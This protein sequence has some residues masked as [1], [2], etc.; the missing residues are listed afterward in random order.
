MALKN[1]F[2]KGF[3]KKLADLFRP[4]YHYL[5][6]LA[7]ALWYR[8]PAK[9]IFVVA[10]TGTKGKTTT[11]EIIGAILKEDGYKVAL[12][13]TLHFE[14]A[15]AEERN[16]FKMTMPGRFFIQKFLRR[17][18]N[19]KCDYAVIEMT[20]EGAQQFRHKFT[21]L[22]A[23]VFTNLA[24]EHIESHGSFENYL[25][26]KLK[27]ARAL[28]KSH[29]DRKFIIANV[30]DPQG[31]TFLNAN[32]PGKFPFS[33][34]N[35]S[36]YLIKKEGLEFALENRKV[37][38]PL[39]GEFNLYNILASIMFARSQN[40]TDEIII[41]AVEKFSGLRGR[42]EKVTLS[43][44]D[45]DSIKQNFSVIVD[46]AH[47]PDSLEKVYQVF[48]NTRLICVLG[49]TGGGRDTWKRPIMG[50]I[51]DRYCD[52]IILTNEDPY[53]EDPRKILQEIHTAIKETA[54]EE[55]LDRRS[56]IRRALGLAKTG[57]TV[58]ITGKGTDPYIMGPHGQKTPWDDAT[59]AREEL[60]NTLNARTA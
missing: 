27:L 15:G 1:Y 50:Q 21:A 57:D 11:V 16:L 44:N 47:T 2:Q 4:I 59:V 7:G 22:N 58:I 49:N 39:S 31:N 5:L 8:F 40:I 29:K 32:V 54:C 24:P 18:V 10:V 38:S 37:I 33:L 14:I 23:L 53:D 46:Y 45:P 25:A 3:W 9:N 19:A 43:S 12:S 30:D 34:K 60:K 41:K 6:A 55:I 56:A 35:T 52:H 13:S 28:E 51:A 42:V 48:Q 26:A 36:P 17:A 20:S